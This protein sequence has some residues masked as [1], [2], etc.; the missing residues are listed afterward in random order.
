VIGVVVPTLNAARTLGETLTSL[1]RNPCVADVVVVD[2]Q[3]SDGTADVAIQHG[4][5]VL[6]VPKEGMYAAIN[7]GCRS[8]ATPWTT[9]LN[10][11]DIAYDWCEAVTYASKQGADC[12][13]G[14]V[15]F[16]DAIGRF[17]HSWTSASPRR[18]LSLYRWGVSP[19]LQPGTIFRHQVFLK[20]GGFDAGLRFVGDADFFLRALL[21]G[22]RFAQLRHPSVAAFRLHAAQLSSRFRQEMAAE[23]RQ[24]LVTQ[25]FKPG[26]MCRLGAAAAYRMVHGRQHLLRAL[27]HKDLAGHVSLKN[28][29]WISREAG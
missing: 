10:A 3:S 14:T 8:L 4:A 21:A 12:V 1:R 7:H 9:Y 20:L 23:H 17:V 25:G 22:F 16:I 18:L 11:D 2:S 15:D 24:M 6:S 5:R 27:R 29:H 26:R 28:S 13:Y 19:L